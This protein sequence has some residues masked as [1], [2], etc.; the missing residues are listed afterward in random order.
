MRRQVFPALAASLVFCSGFAL[1]D[2]PSHAP[3]HGWRKKNDPGYVG[4]TGTTWDRDYGV[5]TGRCNREE[6]GAVLG[7]VIGGAVGARG[8][9]EHRTVATLLGVAVGALIG[10][11][12]GREFDEADRGCLAHSLEM[13]Q[14]GRNITWVNATTGVHYQLVPGRGMKSKGS[15]CRPFVLTATYGGKKEQRKGKAC[16]S[17]AGEWNL[18]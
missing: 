6:I 15:S 13:S 8:S 2:P 5:S 17:R 12:I 18:S 14:S 11:R 3:A 9:E 1:A 4:Y 10:S 7:G 16:Q